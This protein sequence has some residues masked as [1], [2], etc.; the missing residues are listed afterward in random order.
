MKLCSAADNFFLN[1]KHIPLSGRNPVFQETLDV[2][3]H[4]LILNKMDLA[5]LSNKQVRN[6]AAVSGQCCN[7]KHKIMTFTLQRT[8]KMLEKSGV[9][10]VVFTDCLKQRDDN[11][12]KVNNHFHF[13]VNS[14]QLAQVCSSLQS[15]QSASRNMYIFSSILQLVPTLVEIIENRPR[16]NRHEVGSL[17][18]I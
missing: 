6:L 14:C 8:L 12:K 1:M 4:L 10:N 2:R 18:I 5:D 11:I 9:R 15:V 16:F 3:P 17:Q 13:V 7:L